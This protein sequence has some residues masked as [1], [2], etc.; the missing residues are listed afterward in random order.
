MSAC[1]F[2]RSAKLPA[3]AKFHSLRQDM[4]P[5]TGLSKMRIRSQDFCYIQLG[6]DNHRRKVCERYFWLVVKPLAKREGL[7]KSHF[8][9]EF[10]SNLGRRKQAFE[11]A[12]RFAKGTTPKE[13]RN[14]FVENEIR[15]EDLARLADRLVVAARS[16][17]V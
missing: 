1:C 16:S 5:Q 8:V 15:C 14:S 3:S 13:S 11:E 4:K 17:I 7:P 2:T 6:H 10:D 9:H 12:D